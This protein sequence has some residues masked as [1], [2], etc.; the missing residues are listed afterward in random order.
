[1]N[2]GTSF[3]GHIYFSS[4]LS[5]GDINVFNSLPPADIFLL[6]AD[7][8]AKALKIWEKFYRSAV[9]ICE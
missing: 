4:F 5:I 9:V 2:T 1:M 6:A 8:F 7:D 3:I